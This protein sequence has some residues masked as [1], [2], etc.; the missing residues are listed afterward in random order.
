[1]WDVAFDF[2]TAYEMSHFQIRIIDTSRPEI[3]DD[4]NGYVV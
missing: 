2:G 4:K 3:E 1:M